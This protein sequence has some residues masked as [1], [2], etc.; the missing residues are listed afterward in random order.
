MAII[1]QE[2]KLDMSMIQMTV[3]FWGFKLY[4]LSL[5]LQSNTASIFSITDPGS[6]GYGSNRK[7]GRKE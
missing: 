7:E 2:H 6:T 5:K 1:S 3:I 4:G